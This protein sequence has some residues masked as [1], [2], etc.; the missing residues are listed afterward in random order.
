MQND[1]FSVGIT[2]GIG[3]GKSLVCKIFSVLGIPIYSSDERAKWLLAH[4]ADLKDQVI[5]HF[6]AEAYDS[7]GNPNRSFLANE[8]FK[9]ESNRQVL[10]S[11][12]HPLVDEDFQR[13]RISHTNSPFTL[14]EA[15]L[16]FETGSYKKLHK[17]VNVSAPEALRI[18]RV[19]LRDHHRDRD[20]V[21]AIMK[22]QWTDA[23]REK[24]A[25]YTLRNDERQLLIPKVT[26]LYRQLC[27][28]AA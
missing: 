9:K 2:G 22:K 21:V 19:L 12:V 28:D 1:F 26:R 3:S 27:D 7:E 14:K 8:I 23:E 24:Q 18:R 16:L 13:W 15:A 17:M 10:N 20:Q 11:L 25:D 4:H 5:R 6:G